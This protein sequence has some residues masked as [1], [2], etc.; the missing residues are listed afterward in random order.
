MSVSIT[1]RPKVNVQNISAP[2][3]KSMDTPRILY[4]QWLLIYVISMV[5]HPM[6]CRET[7]TVIA[8]VDTEHC[9]LDIMEPDDGGNNS[10]QYQYM[11]LV[12]VSLTTY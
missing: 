10:S 7:S 12:L 8:G 9:L 6:R 1:T 11:E 3:D 5:S 2:I 4:T